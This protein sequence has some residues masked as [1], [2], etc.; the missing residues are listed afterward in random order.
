VNRE[1]SLHDYPVSTEC[2]ITSAWQ[3]LPKILPKEGSFL[4]EN[5]QQM[6][7][8]IVLESRAEAN[9][10]KVAFV[11]IAEVN[12]QFEEY[13]TELVLWLSLHMGNKDL[14]VRKAA[15]EFVLLCQKRRPTIKMLQRVLA[16]ISMDSNERHRV[17]L[18]VNVHKELW[19]AHVLPFLQTL[20]CDSAWRSASS[21]RSMRCEL[22]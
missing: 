6:V 16:V 20:L 13:S 1:G 8:I 18:F 21:R 4:V 11:C 10:I 14:S 5:I 7:F 15:S 3:K 17:N 19:N 2:D 12:L 22:R 9:Q